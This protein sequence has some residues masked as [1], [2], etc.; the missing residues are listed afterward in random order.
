MRL[1]TLDAVSGK[2]GRKKISYV[3]LM[4]RRV[5]NIL[6]VSSPYDSFTFEEDGRLT[7]LLFSEYLELNL[8]YAPN[9]MRVSTAQE[10]LDKLR[11]TSFDLVISM[12]RVGEMEVQDF[13]L[14]VMKLKPDL[15]VV[16]LTYD[17]R[18]LDVLEDLGRMPG[19]DR[20][21]VWLGD[22]R[23]FLAIIKYIE[24]RL[25]AEQDAATAG[26]QCI[27]L[28]EDNVRFYSSYLPLVYTELVQQ[29]QKLMSDGLNRMDMM[30]RMR[31]RP[32]ILLATSYDEGEKYYKQHRD[33]VSGVILDA[34]FHKG[35]VI[36]PGAGIDFAKM[37][38]Q[39][40]P[41]CPIL[42]QSSDMENR[43]LAHA[44]GADF[45]NKGSPT[46]VS[47]TSCFICRAASKWERRAI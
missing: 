46:W 17:T 35:D 4:Q 37:I 1:S 27:I 45:I 28:I 25:N 26:V 32:K 16:L 30:L 47:E 3:S 24:D 10:A 36:D 6:L 42:I 2:G 5:R 43:S 11:T 14:E 13:G 44:L 29:T 41:D 31:A 19:I 18:E 12:L 33:H 8:H 9:I 23:L 39:N 21:F 7:E 20:V 15:P 22:V 34:A 40:S 38:R